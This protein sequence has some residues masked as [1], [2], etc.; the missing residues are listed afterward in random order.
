[1]SNIPRAREIIS[2]AASMLPIGDPA[3]AMLLVAL[4]MLTRESPVKK[5]HVMSRAL[6]LEVACEIYR[7][8][9]QYSHLSMQEIGNALRVNPGRVSEVLTGAK[10]PEAREITLKEIK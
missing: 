5:A 10:F 9:R 8:Y 1:M 7:Y 4:P 2:Q 3:R 6:T